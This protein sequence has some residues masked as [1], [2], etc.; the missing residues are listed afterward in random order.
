MSHVPA[1]EAIR[2]ARITYRQLDH[3][4]THSMIRCRVAN[5]GTGNRR[6]YTEREVRI[7]TLMASL[8]HEGVDPT[9]AAK[10]ARRLVTKGTARLGRFTITE[11]TANAA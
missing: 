4:T 11:R 10:V 1:T 6:R 2:V 9:T 8:V 5:P 7:L 3:W